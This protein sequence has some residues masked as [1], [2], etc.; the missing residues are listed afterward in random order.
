MIRTKIVC[1]L[2]PSSSDPQVMR[3]ML[4]AGMDV[5]RLNF[6]HGTH[7]DHR[8]LYEN[9]RAT[10]RE[11]G[12]QVAVMMDLQGPKIRMGEL[13]GDHVML[14]TGAEVCITTRQVPGTAERISTTYEQLAHDVTPG[15]RIL[16]CDGLLELEALATG[17]D[18]VR[19]RVVI[20]GELGE[21]KGINLPGTPI[22]A[23]SLTEKDREDAALGIEL[24]VDYVALSF[25]RSAD[26]VR[27]LRDFLALQGADIP[28]VAKLEKA[29]AMDD[30]EA[31]VAASD[32]V[33]VARGDLAV[34]TSPEQVPIFQKQIIERCRG[35]RVPVITAT[36]MLETMTDSPRPTRAEASDVANA[37]FDGTDAVM[38][39]GETAIGSYPVE[40][41]AMMDRIAATTEA[42]LMERAHLSTDPAPPGETLTVADAIARGAAEVAEDV[43]ARVIVAFTHSGSTARLLSKCRPDMPIIAATPIES[44]AHRAC[45]YWGCQPML[46]PHATSTDEMIASVNE[47]II[48]ERR[49]AIGDPVVVVAGTPVGTSGT[50]NLIRVLRCEQPAA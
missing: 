17:E 22:S 23:P 1:T 15:D 49:A 42:A 4:E 28:I 12:R 34:E 32:A 20:G 18:E 8:E 45:L 25:V 24:G 19:C 30:L 31:I 27:S 38:L 33:M 37:I 46:I 35:A 3:R 36:Q 29:E 16:L 21:R 43:D 44:A 10:A 40:A 6:S 7:D 41:V 50:T 48:R 2:G 26:D 14:E 13:Q 5:A 11:M 9:I 47:Q 39:S